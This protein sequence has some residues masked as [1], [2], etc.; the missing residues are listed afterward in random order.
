MKQGLGDSVGGYI[1]NKR[2][3]GA[4]SGVGKGVGDTV[5]GVTGGRFCYDS[6]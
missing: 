4:V 1:P 6:V 3:G 2:V 5:S